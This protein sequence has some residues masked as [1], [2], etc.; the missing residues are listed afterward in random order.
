MDAAPHAETLAGLADVL[1]NGPE[2]DSEALT[3]FLG[4]QALGRKMQASGL[5]RAQMAGQLR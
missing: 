1:V 4:G 2:R 5:S 3:D